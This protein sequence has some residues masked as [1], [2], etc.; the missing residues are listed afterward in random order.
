MITDYNNYFQMHQSVSLKKCFWQKG[1]LRKEIILEKNIW[2][3]YSPH[4]PFLIH[5]VTIKLNT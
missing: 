1:E 4:Y 5:A 2:P 3:G